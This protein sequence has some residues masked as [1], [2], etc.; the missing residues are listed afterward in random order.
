MIEM[1][2]PEEK[3][4]EEKAVTAAAEEAASAVQEE[5]P[6]QEPEMETAEPT[7]EQ[8]QEEAAEP[9][10]EQP[11]EETAEQPGASTEEDELE[12]LRKELE[13]VRAQAAEYLEGWQRTQA[14]FANYRKRQ[15]AER[16]QWVQM[17]NAALIAKILPILDDLERAEK[18]LPPGL[19]RLTWIEGIFLIKR[20]LEMILEAEGV[21]PIETEGKTFDPLYH[22]A[23]TYEEVEGYEDGQII[24]E[25]QR[26]YMLGDRVIRPALVRVARAVEKVSPQATEAGEAVEETADETSD[27]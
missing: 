3:M 20:R 15:E 16:Q 13:E 24:G 19:E 6:S 5:Q 17:S 23:V 18:T 9:T 7:E 11:E 26:G 1:K 27:S 12:R 21:R 22:E 2:E 25:V 8:V 14:E 4:E 10:E